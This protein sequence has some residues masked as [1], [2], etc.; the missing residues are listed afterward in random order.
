MAVAVLEGDVAGTVTFRGGSWSQTVRLTGGAA[1]TT[2][3][4]VQ[5]GGH[6]YRLRADLIRHHLRGS[7]FPEDRPAAG[8][9]R[10]DL[11][12]HP[13]PSEFGGAKHDRQQ[14]ER[15]DEY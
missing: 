12:E 15:G 11:P 2:R 5:A 8:Q 6:G 4:V 14:H 1:T 10:A 3:T 7:G 9:L 13:L